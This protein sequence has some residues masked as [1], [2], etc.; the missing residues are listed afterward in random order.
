VSKIKLPT[1]GHQIHNLQP[2]WLRHCYV[3]GRK[4]GLSPDL[5]REVQ[6]EYEF[7]IAYPK[8]R[9]TLG[10]L[11]GPR[12]FCAPLF[13]M[14]EKYTA[15]VIP[16][17]EIDLTVPGT[18]VKMSVPTLKSVPTHKQQ[19]ALD[20]FVENAE[21]CGYRIKGKKVHRP[22]GKEML[23]SVES[24]AIV[25]LL[26]HPTATNREIALVVGCH[27]DYLSSVACSRFRHARERLQQLA[28]ANVTEFPAGLKTKSGD[29]EAWE[30]DRSITNERRRNIERLRREKVAVLNGE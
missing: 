22:S 20:E 24:R 13:S 21:A 11:R 15:P 9:R 27:P 16:K 5:Q 3:Y 6:D 18:G 19:A 28:A 17:P 30:N 25:Y 7:R 4:L 12:V 29:I 26:D 23:G 14:E 10:K 8:N 2:T 1:T